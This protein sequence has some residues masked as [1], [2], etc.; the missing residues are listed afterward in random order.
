[1]HGRNAHLNLVPFLLQS[2]GEVYRTI[3]VP[4]LTRTKPTWHENTVLALTPRAIEYKVAVLA[5]TWCLVGTAPEL[6]CS[7]IF[8]DVPVNPTTQSHTP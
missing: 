3:N 2:K 8:A 5:D 1:M 4:Q 7:D 6:V